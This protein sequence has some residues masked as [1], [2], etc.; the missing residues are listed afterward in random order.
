MVVFRLTDWRILSWRH[1]WN[2]SGLGSKFSGSGL[3]FHQKKMRF[4]ALDF[5]LEY[6]EVHPS[7]KPGIQNRMDNMKENILYQLENIGIMDIFKH[8]IWYRK[9]YDVPVPYWTS[10][11]FL[12]LDIERLCCFIQLHKRGRR[13]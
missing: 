13:I 6:Y 1:L 5:L 3:S 12:D 4:E 2:D 9:E 7:H 10:E 8:H 11:R